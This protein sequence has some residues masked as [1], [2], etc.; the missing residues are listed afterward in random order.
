[1]IKMCLYWIAWGLLFVWQLPQNLVALVYL[2]FVRREKKVTFQRGVWFFAAPIHKGGFSMGNFVVLSLKSGLSGPSYDHEFG[3]CIQSR[4][5]GPLY[6]PIV[7]VCSGLHNLLYN[8]NH[9][10]YIYWT[11][12]WA[13]RL[14]GIDGYNGG[15]E[16]H[17]EGAIY[18]AYTRLVDIIN[19]KP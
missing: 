2:L 5:L 15:L 12:R 7:G 19:L 4:I 13:N 11:E 18:T 17:K 10:Y 14:G 16:F 8:G 1:M 9:T 3:H 6:L